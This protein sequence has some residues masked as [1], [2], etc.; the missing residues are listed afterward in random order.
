M[1]KL[2]KL[3]MVF[4]TLALVIA[5]SAWGGSKKEPE[6]A[7]QGGQPAAPAPAPAPAGGQSLQPAQ[8]PS[9]VQPAITN[10]GGQPAAPV[11]APAPAGAQAFAPA[12]PPATSWTPGVYQVQESQ[13]PG[14]K[15]GPMVFVPAGEFIMGM[16]AEDALSECRKVSQYCKPE[17]FTDEAPVHRVNLDAYYIDKHEVTQGEY[18]KCVQ[19]KAC[20][21]NKELPGMPGMFIITVPRWPAV[22][23]YWEDAR[24]Y[25]GWAGK[26]LPTEAEWEKAARGTDG[27]I[28]PWGNQAPSCG[29]A[30]FFSGCGGKP[31]EV[32]SKPGGASP[33]GA[34]DMAGNV[35]EWVADWYGENY[36]SGSPSQNPK[37]PS[38]GTFRVV[39]GGGWYFY[40]G[41]LLVSVRN[42]DVPSFRLGGDGG[43]RCARD[44]P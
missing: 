21:N 13:R 35:W 33:Y 12:Q 28:Y 43:F 39:R 1:E 40:P 42:R 2:K 41:G 10:Q 8:Q 25:C 31:V 6:V 44:G 30:N 29:L 27:R 20:N 26:R 7:K 17:W 15:G 11:P 9:P 38:S 14:T 5:L 36:Y 22:L 32:G 3:L 24:T 34:L 4:M 18:D 16:S 37:G 23:V 19:A